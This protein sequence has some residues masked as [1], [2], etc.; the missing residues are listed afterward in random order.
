MKKRIFNL[1]SRGE[2]IILAIVFVIILSVIWSIILAE[3]ST[4]SLGGSTNTTLG[5]Y[6]TSTPTTSGTS[7]SGG[8]TGSTTTY[9]T[10]PTTTSTTTSSTSGSGSTSSTP[11]TVTKNVPLA[12]EDLSLNGSPMSTYIPLK[13]KNKA[14]NV[15]GFSIGRK[16]NNEPTWSNLAEIER[17]SAV[18]YYDNTVVEGKIYDYR[19]KACYLEIGCSSYTYLYKI[20]TPQGSAV[21]FQGT[22]STESS[23]STINTTAGVNPTTT[24]TIVPDG[25]SSATTKTTVEPPP[26]I[27]DSSLKIQ[28]LGIVVEDHQDVV[29][30]SKEEL[31]KIINESI[32][33]IVEND[34]SPEQEVNIA[35][36]D[37]LFEELL[38]SVDTSLST[39]AIVTLTDVKELKTEVN[40][41]IKNIAST[42]S[43][44]IFISKTTTNDTDL[45]DVARILDL[46][47]EAVNN[48]SEPLKTQEADLLYKDSNSDGVSDYDS[49]YVYNINPVAPS[50]VSTYQGKDIGAR[51]KILLGF[52]PAK[53]EL[54]K[55][56]KEQPI[57]SQA[58]T[59]LTYEVKE[60]TLTPEKEVV[61]RGQALPNSFVTVYIYST[62]IIVTVR[63]DER[64]EWQYILDK[65]LENGDHTIYTATVNNSGNIIA[66]SS[67]YL[68]TKTAEAVTLLDTNTAGSLGDDKPGLLKNNNLYV[69][70]VIVI[71]II[72]MILTLV[73]ITSKRNKEGI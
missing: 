15:Y 48:Q 5:T 44:D 68:F 53:T 1:S 6:T 59:V 4:S 57:E 56:K 23:G 31:E 10:T 12:P 66:K 17:A 14:T 3:D 28:N 64:G 39:R 24:T 32:A 62:P 25:I 18:S 47:S 21:S 37:L 13:W 11:P 33:D 55:V 61:I 46:L 22:T 63:T 20:A 50:P 19:I 27:N 70:M 40:E 34:G 42:T 38:R 29:D 2:E 52:D 30:E 67:P 73:G 58:L 16:L 72:M 8:G 35:E 54:V 26:V 7:T 60:I 65:E 41:V 9:T 45:K 36:V 43:E 51:E 69:V 71:V 49:I